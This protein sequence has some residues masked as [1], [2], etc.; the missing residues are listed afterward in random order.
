[1]SSFNKPDQRFGGQRKWLKLKDFSS[2]INDNYYKINGD[3]L[4][5][6]DVEGWEKK[7]LESMS[8]LQENRCPK[9]I[10]RV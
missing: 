6:M 4:L 8:G 7:V 9:Y 5:M 2:I 10:F 3:Y 1:M